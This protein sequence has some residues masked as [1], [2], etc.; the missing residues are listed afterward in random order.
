[1]AQL[2]NIVFL[3]ADQLRAD[4]LGCYGADFVATPHIDSLA[5]QGVRYGRAYSTS[6]ICV[7][8]RASLLTG[9][10]AIKNG[11]TSNSQWLRPDLHQLGVH[12]WPELLAAAGYRTAAVGK[13]HF[14][15]WDST[16]GF[17]YKVGAE[18][19][20][21]IHIRDDY[22]HFLAAHGHRKLHGNEHEG[23]HEHKGAIVN[24]IPWEYSADHFV[25]KEACRFLRTYGG[26][27]P[28]ALMV[29]FPGPHCPYDP[30]AEFLTQVDPAAM[31]EAIPY[32]AENT[33]RL[34][35]Q[36]VYGN[37][38]PWN[39]VDYTEFTAA[40]KQKIR[41]HYTALVQQIDYE[42]GQI[43]ATLREQ[44]LLENTMMVFASDHGDYLGDHDLIGKGTFY[45]SSIHIPLIVRPAGGVEAQTV[46]APVML[47]DVTATLL[48]WAGVARPSYMDARPLPGLGL[49]DSAPRSHLMG[50]TSTGW[51]LYD[52]AWKLCK[53]ATG[54]THLFHLAED[55]TEQHNRV[56]DPACWERY[57]AM[58]AQLAQAIMQ[59][60]VASHGDKALD[61]TNAYWAD[62]TYGMR[63]WRRQYPRG[64]L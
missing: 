23:Y 54:D 59:A 12:T 32:V 37:R 55:P 28:F 57:L 49:P 56:R 52:G 48:A 44:G 22:Y 11:V 19:K 39:G 2:P 40:H 25:G 21:W 61:T 30:N 14:Y 38:Q 9:M 20:R 45:E 62:Q 3:L 18:D 17:Q 46:D 60:L 35:A 42:V 43:L 50:A 29:S 33:A 1:M 51:M 16:L 36:N 24:R 5:A 7:P 15:P 41:A 34:R 63:G 64:Y 58:E 8:A 13:M 47:T 6:P 4:F 26:E 27:Q 31:P 53:Y 10:D